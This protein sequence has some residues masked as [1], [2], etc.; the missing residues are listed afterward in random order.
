MFE[1]GVTAHRH[2]QHDKAAVLDS[3]CAI[4]DNYRRPTWSVGSME[5]VRLVV[6]VLESACFP[7]VEVYRNR[8]SCP[9]T[10]APKL[11]VVRKKASLT[12]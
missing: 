12:S 5:G 11:L 1:Y 8:L 4:V 2:E 3:R 6:A 10:V 7:Q 9:S